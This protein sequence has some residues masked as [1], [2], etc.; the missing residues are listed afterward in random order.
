MTIKNKKPT[1]SI[2][3]RN[4]QPNPSIKEITVENLPDIIESTT[5]TNK[6]TN[7]C[8]I[9][10]HR[11]RIEQ[12]RTFLKT[13]NSPRFAFDIY[14]IDQNNAD[15]FNRG[16]LLNIGFY[17]ASRNKNYDR[18][19][20]HDVD[21]YP[22]ITLKK[23]YTIDPQKYPIIHYAS[24]L[25]GYKYKFP[26]FFGGIVA[27]NK[28]TFTQINGFPNNIFGW[29][30]EDDI[31]R[32]RVSQKRLTI[33]RPVRGQYE[34][35]EHDKPTA[36]ELSFKTTADK[37]TKI[38][39]DRENW[40]KNG[41]NQVA[42]KFI[43]VVQAKNWRDFITN[44]DVPNI[45][46]NYTPLADVPT[47]TTTGTGPI[48]YY[49]IDYLAQ[50][51][52]TADKSMSHLMHKDYA[53]DERKKRLAS[54]NGTPVFYNNNPQSPYYNHLQP[55]LYWAD[56]QEHI[57]DTF[58]PL[59]R[60]STINTTP[61]S[62]LLA[63]AFEPY[64]EHNGTKLGKQD[65]KNTIKHI[66]DT[67]NELLYFR[68]RNGHITHKYYIFNVG[69]PEIDWY[70]DLKWSSSTGTGTA[71]N[72]SDIQDF[73]AKAKI[74]YYMTLAK[75][76]FLRANGCLLGIES[77]DYIRELNSSYVREFADMLEY[78]CAKLPMPDAD[79]II[80]RKDFA[81]LTTNNTYAYE[82]LLKNVAIPN[83]P[84]KWYPVCSQSAIPHKHLDIPVPS[85]DEW[86]SLQH[87]PLANA[88]QPWHKRRNTAFFRGSSTGCGTTPDNNTRLRIA[89]ISNRWLTLKTRQELIDVAISKLT[90][91]IKAFDQIPNVIDK[92]HNKALLGKFADTSEQAKY[93]Y[94]FN[95]PGNA[96]AY[97]YPTEFYK[98]AVIINVANRLTPR[99]WFEPLLKE[100]VD[101]VELRDVSDANTQET[102]LYNTVKWLR[103]N[104]D[105]A[106][107]IAQ[108]GVK[109]AQRYITA[110]TMAHY[111]QLLA[112]NINKIMRHQ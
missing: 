63:N 33:Y 10:P 56:I 93:K 71:T 34:L 18:Y 91:R 112:Y 62:P 60:A 25:L 20:F 24:P 59:K 80:N 11:N 8:I 104:D 106:Q 26:H 44:Y 43:T 37:W 105:D 98:G 29:G 1:N 84:K 111:W 82:H 17:I 50:H 5:T 55:L 2:T 28:Q 35:P 96:Q 45:Q 83:A 65:L 89:H 4:R 72:V 103:D 12:L 6:A 109:F 15:K 48:Y 102:L 39:S 9:V 97:R 7:V 78:S 75:P 36:N 94:I 69:S 68:I 85:A 49:K 47:G 110:D 100:G 86:T 64:I 74:P 107:H 92:T 22:D 57:I 101:Y 54:F 31:L 3:K 67:Y 23:Q 19:I 108:N 21:S 76:H 90:S 51:I 32:Q 16:L 95:I 38:A 61:L 66:F 99:M 13:I 87:T 77:T 41:V 40:Q 52:V 27:F 42:N 79:I 58:T 53:N 73:V 14:V 46:L 88:T 30:A 81:Y 70:R